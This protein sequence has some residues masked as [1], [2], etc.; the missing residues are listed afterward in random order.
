MARIG[1][2]LAD[3]NIY[4][5]LKFN[6]MNKIIIVIIFLCASNFNS[7]AQ[8]K[9]GNNSKTINPN[10]I[11]EVESDTLGLLLPRLNLTSVSLPAPLKA[12]VQG[13][14]VYNKT[15]AF[16]GTDSALVSGEYYNDGTKWIRISKIVPANNFFYMPSIPIRT[17]SLGN[18]L[19]VNL[20]NQYRLQFTSPAVKSNSAPSSIPYFMNAT[21][22]YYY[23]SYFPNTI[24]SNVSINDNGLMTYDVIST[25]DECS[26]INVVF[27]P[28]E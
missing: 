23:I 12:H 25:T 16:S 8:I 19:T 21:D 20:Y 4:C 5:K 11:L 13:M 1:G 26:Y 2:S 18:G 27:V 17:D 15:N 14:H 3:K 6:N 28:K 7:I 22:I 10:A 24:I 9:V